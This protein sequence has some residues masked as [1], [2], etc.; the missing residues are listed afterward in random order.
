MILQEFG[1]E[2]YYDHIC[3]SI[4]R[5]SFFR[6]PIDRL[7]LQAK[8]SGEAVPFDEHSSILCDFAQ[9]A[10]WTVPFVVQGRTLCLNKGILAL[11]NDSQFGRGNNGLQENANAMEH[12]LSCLGEYFARV[13]VELAR[14][15]EAA[16]VEL[17]AVVEAMFRY[18]YP[19][20]SRIQNKYIRPLLVFAHE[21][22]MPI[23]K[24]A[25]ENVG[26]LKQ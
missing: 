12:T 3:P 17:F 5:V 25:L 24:E 2:V 18:L 16:D 20:R 7:P 11:H 22:Q 1:P 21:H 6:S 13:T 9:P 14:A 10:S 8:Q 19:S 15:L 26:D 23:F 4:L